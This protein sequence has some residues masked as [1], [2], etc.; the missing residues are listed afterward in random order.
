MCWW[1]LGDASVSYVVDAV[2]DFWAAF[3]SDLDA[4]PD[5]QVAELQQQ[6]AAIVWPTPTTLA[7]YR[8]DE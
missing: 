5:D 1:R 2:N 4:L 3:A 7:D 6:Y 8:H